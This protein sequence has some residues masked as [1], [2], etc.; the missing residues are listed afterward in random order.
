MQ[1]DGLIGRLVGGMIRRSVRARFRGL[2]WRPPTLPTERPLIFAANHHGWFDGYVMYHVVTK[3]GVPALDWIEEFDSFPLFARVGG[4]PFPVGKP[5][6]RAATVRKTIRRMLEE[7]RSLVLF[8]EGVLHEP[9][10]VLPFGR[11]LE[12]VAAKTHAMIIPTAIRYTFDLHERPE[13]WVRFGD[14]IDP[15]ATD[16]AETARRSVV[17]L[18]ETPMAP[19]EFELLA[20]GTLDVNERWDKR[21]KR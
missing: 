7:G 11:S 4:M 3:L 9:P 2:Y 6:V 21:R 17:S 20:S 12:V 19:S 15:G 13:A 18:L 1:E 8:A 14:A 10:S 5:E 16:L